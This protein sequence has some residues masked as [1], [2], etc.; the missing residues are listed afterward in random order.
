MYSTHL[1]ATPRISGDD[2]NVMP[3]VC[4]ISL[5]ASQSVAFLL[6]SSPRL[7]Y[8]KEQSNMVTCKPGLIFVLCLKRH[9][10][11]AVSHVFNEPC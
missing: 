6:S 9:Q 5:G 7:M 3:T 10:K 1:S 2:V 4:F 11:A 8:P